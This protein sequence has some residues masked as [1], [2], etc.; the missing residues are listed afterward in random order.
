MVDHVVPGTLGGD[1]TAMDN[2]VTACNP[3]NAIKADFTLEQ[4]GWRQRPITKSDWAGLS[5]HYEALWKL[6]GRP[7]PN[8]HLSWFRDL[9]ISPR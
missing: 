3:C 2:L 7:D 5:E 1:W 6:A 4:L 9:G 8:R